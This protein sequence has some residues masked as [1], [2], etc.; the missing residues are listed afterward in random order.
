MIVIVTDNEEGGEEGEHERAQTNSSSFTSVAVIA[1]ARGHERC[2][3]RSE[4]VCVC[5]C[6]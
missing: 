3:M 5:V 4:C 2:D 6:V 1:L